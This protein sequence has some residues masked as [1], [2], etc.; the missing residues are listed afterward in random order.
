MFF[1]ACEG[2]FDKL[3]DTA[4]LFRNLAG[5][6][7]RS[8]GGKA[9]MQNIWPLF[10]DP[11]PEIMKPWTAEELEEMKVRHNKIFSSNGRT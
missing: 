2:Y 5:I 9:D 7:N 6:V 11:K 3:E 1:A 4:A 8:M 10:N